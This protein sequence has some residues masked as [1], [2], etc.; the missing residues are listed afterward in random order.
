MWT[1]LVDG[2]NNA[3][4]SFECLFETR[5]HGEMK[6]VIIS[7]QSRLIF[8]Y[9]FPVSSTETLQYCLRVLIRWMASFQ[10]VCLMLKSS[11]TSVNQM[12]RVLCLHSHG[13]SLICQYSDALRC[14]SNR[15]YPRFLV[16]GR[17]YKS[18]IQRMYTYPLGV[19]LS[20]RC[21]PAW[22]LLSC[23]WQIHAV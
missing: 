19:V 8:M 4:K 21:I 11:M 23:L 2:G 14:S 1:N 18:C 9:F 7:S 13:T 16:W 15:S 6:L 3:V 10:Q 20:W 5:I 17:L 12:G 22:F